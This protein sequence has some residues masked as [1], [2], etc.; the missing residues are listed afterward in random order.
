MGHY[1]E[2]GARIM[3]VYIKKDTW[4]KIDALPCTD[5]NGFQT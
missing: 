4:F 1:P 3:L 2:D 5:M